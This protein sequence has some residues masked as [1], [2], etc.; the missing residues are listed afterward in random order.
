[1]AR[2]GHGVSRLEAHSGCHWLATTITCVEGMRREEG[3]RAGRTEG[4]FEEAEEEVVVCDHH[5]ALCALD[6]TLCQL[7]LPRAVSASEQAHTQS[8]SPSLAASP[9][10]LGTAR[11]AP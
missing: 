9:A 4:D 10:T 2:H 7:T 1:V 8:F 5:H 6:S 11:S 3:R